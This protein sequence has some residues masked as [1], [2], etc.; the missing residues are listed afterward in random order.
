MPVQAVHPKVKFARKRLSDTISLSVEKA[1]AHLN[2]PGQFPLPSGKESLEYAIVDLFTVLPKRK[3]EKFLEKMKA[4]ITA[5]P[6]ARQQKY[7][8]L[9]AVDL[10]SKK[11][12]ASQVETITVPDQMKFTEADIE[13][14]KKPATKKNIQSTVKAKPKTI[15]P[16]Q[17]VAGAALQFAV[18]SITC[19]ETN[20]IRKDEISISAFV[21]SSS[22]ELQESNNFFSGKFK[23]GDSKSLGAAG[24][25]FSFNISDSVGTVFPASFAASVFLTE[26]DLFANKEVSEKVGAILR[27]TGKIIATG[28]LITLFFPAVGLPLSFTILGV[29]ALIM[30]VGD[31]LLFFASDEISEIAADELL[32]ETPPFAG[33][34]FAREITIGF[35]DGGFILGGSYKLAVRWTVV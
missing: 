24:S 7:S 20:D 15:Q 3:K 25:L 5:T 27:V 10:H 4:A 33:E 2:N 8:T 9:A 34:T 23:K 31:G 35:I 11:A 1:A 32:L 6:A 29:G 14:F 30:F 13:K 16:R 22:G 18:E 28:S 19:T 26:K 21:L 12:V 17:A